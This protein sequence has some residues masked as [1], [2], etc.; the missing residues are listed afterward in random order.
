[1]R[2]KLNQMEASSEQVYT[3]LQSKLNEKNFLSTEVESTAELMV[4]NRTS[5]NMT[6]LNMTSANITEMA[7]NVTTNTTTVVL[8]GTTIT[9]TV[10][11]L[12]ETMD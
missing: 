7:R 11:I 1:M 9:T 2:T 8:N 10:V 12:D 3:D 6:S 4:A 5:A